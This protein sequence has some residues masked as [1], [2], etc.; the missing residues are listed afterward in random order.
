[1]NFFLGRVTRHHV[2]MGWFARIGDAP[3]PASAL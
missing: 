3:P 1:M 2:D